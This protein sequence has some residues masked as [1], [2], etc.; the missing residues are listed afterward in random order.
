MLSSLSRPLQQSPESQYHTLFP[1]N[2]NGHATSPT[3]APASGVVTSPTTLLCTTIRTDRLGRCVPDHIWP[4]ALYQSDHVVSVVLMAE[5]VTLTGSWIG[6][7][8]PFETV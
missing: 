6:T 8:R 3:T 1:G 2:S 5:Y 7:S 4:Q